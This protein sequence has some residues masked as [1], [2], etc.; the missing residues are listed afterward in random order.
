MK[1]T[2]QIENTFTMESNREEG[3]TNKEIYQIIKDKKLQAKDFNIRNCEPNGEPVD[4][5]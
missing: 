4:E 1:W 5:Y 2:V 3:P